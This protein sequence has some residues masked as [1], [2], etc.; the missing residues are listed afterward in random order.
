[1][2]TG[3]KLEEFQAVDMSDFNTRLVVESFG[4]AFIL[5]VNNKRPT[6]L[7]AALV[8]RFTLSSS[9][10]AGIRDFDGISMCTEGIKSHNGFFS[11]GKFLVRRDKMDLL[12]LLNAVS[13]C[14]DCKDD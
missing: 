13:T 11:F 4:D 2:T 9:K 14:E 5:T 3:G 8:S 1:M 12:N 10:L 6:V 7:A